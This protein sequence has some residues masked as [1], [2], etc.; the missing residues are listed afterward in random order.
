MIQCHDWGESGDGA[1]R[2]ME[3]EACWLLCPLFS[4]PTVYNYS[5]VQAAGLN[6]VWYHVAAGQDLEQPIDFHHPDQRLSKEREKLWLQP[7]TMQD[8][9]QYICML[10]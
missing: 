2:V 9:G 1:V 5:S 8:A 3:G 6:L 7:T 4:H 10:R